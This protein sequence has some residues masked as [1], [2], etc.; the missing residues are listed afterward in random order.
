MKESRFGSANS[1]RSSDESESHRRD[2]SSRHHR[3]A[4]S[5]GKFNEKRENDVKCRSSSHRTSVFKSY[6][7]DFAKDYIAEQQ[8]IE[9]QKWLIAERADEDINNLDSIRNTREG[10]HGVYDP[11][12][13]PLLT[14]PSIGSARDAVKDVDRKGESNRAQPVDK[15]RSQLSWKEAVV[16]MDRL[17]YNFQYSRIRIHIL[18]V[19]VLFL[20]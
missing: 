8:V 6:A 15:F 12:R 17:R 3:A 10:S 1:A 13:D 11:L 9:A 5:T 14:A 16:F 20:A 19:S 2:K 18:M 7:I 4:F